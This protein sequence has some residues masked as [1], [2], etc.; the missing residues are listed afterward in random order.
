[1]ISAGSTNGCFLPGIT[2][3]EVL[4]RRVVLDMETVGT[5]VLCQLSSLLLFSLV[6]QPMDGARCWGAVSANTTAIGLSSAK[7][8]FITIQ[9]LVLSLKHI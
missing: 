6:L 9:Y 1:M 3:A 8:K 4:N 7:R 2:V 5:Q